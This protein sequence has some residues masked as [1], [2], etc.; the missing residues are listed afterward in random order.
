MF[1]SIYT[2]DIM[3]F[4]AQ[5]LFERGRYMYTEIVAKLYDEIDVSNYSETLPPY[6]VVFS[7]SSR[8]RVWLFFMSVSLYIKE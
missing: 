6:N 1:L 4:C 3:V 8:D 5:V 2:I 7:F